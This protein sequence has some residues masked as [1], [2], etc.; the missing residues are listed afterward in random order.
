MFYIILRNPIYYGGVY[1]KSYKDEPISTVDG[2]HDPLISKRLF[3]QVQSV[4]GAKKKKHHVTHSR[5]NPKFPLKGFLLC[6]EC[7][8]PLTASVCKGRSEHY[9]Y[10]HCISPCK[11][12]YRIEEAET[13]VVSF[14]KSIS[15]IKPVLE[16]LQVIIKEQLKKQLLTSKLGPQAL[17]TRETYR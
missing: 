5:I 8:R 9:S 16:L 7:P 11:G 2:I 13:V 12:S 14:L 3:D 15:L 17:R 1:I 6:P 10:Y 4:L